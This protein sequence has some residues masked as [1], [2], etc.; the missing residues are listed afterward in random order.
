VWYYVG[1]DPNPNA[2]SWTKIAEGT[3]S[4][5]DLLTLTASVSALGRYLKIYLPDSN[6]EPHTS[7]AEIDVFGYE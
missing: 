6:N 2:A 5:G 1:N 7:V 4:S 3:Y